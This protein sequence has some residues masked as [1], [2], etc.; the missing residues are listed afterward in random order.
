MKTTAEI[1][2]LNNEIWALRLCDLHQPRARYCLHGRY[3][4][5][6]WL[7]KDRSASRGSWNSV[8]FHFQSNFL[9][10]RYIPRLSWPWL[11]WF[12][13]SRFSAKRNWLQNLKL[14]G[15]TITTIGEEKLFNPRLS[16]GKDQFIHIMKT[17]YTPPSKGDGTWLKFLFS[18]SK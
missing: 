14:S 4:L 17:L 6:S 15:R 11:Q 10:T 12:V 13:L 16:G 3:A 8:L 9:S 7:W 18:K 1:K 5:N 2:G